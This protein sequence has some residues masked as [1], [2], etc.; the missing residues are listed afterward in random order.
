[1]PCSMTEAFSSRQS[2]CVGR[3]MPASANSSATRSVAGAHSWSVYLSKNSPE[4]Y[5][6]SSNPP[7]RWPV[8]MAIRFEARSAWNSTA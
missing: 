8:S 2:S 4:A 7:N 3:A 5:F 1:M 6:E